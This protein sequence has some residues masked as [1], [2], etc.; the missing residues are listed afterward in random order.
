M[1]KPGRGKILL[2]SLAACF[3]LLAG[4]SSGTET[5]QAGGAETSPEA[6]PDGEQGGAGTGGLIPSLS[7]PAPMV[8]LLVGALLVG[9]LLATLPKTGEP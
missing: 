1:N 8:A 6:A 5:P 7:R 3:V 9:I 2:L 4:C